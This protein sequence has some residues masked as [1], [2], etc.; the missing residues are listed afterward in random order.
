MRRFISRFD[1]DVTNRLRILKVTQNTN[2]KMINEFNT[3]IQDHPVLELYHVVR[4][5]DYRPVID[6]IFSQGFEGGLHGNRGPGIYVSSHSQY[7]AFWGNNEHVIV[8]HVI[9]DKD[10]LSRHTSDV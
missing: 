6:R 1:F 2:S 10:S 7:A 4:S 9:A 5:P 3:R 8:C